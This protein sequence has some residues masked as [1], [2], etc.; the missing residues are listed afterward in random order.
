MNAKLFFLLLY[1]KALQILN[2]NTSIYLPLT[3]ILK[4]AMKGSRS[5]NNLY[6]QLL[7]TITHWSA[8]HTIQQM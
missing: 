3:A 5:L 8:Y 6:L 1:L 4:F 2:F 7:G